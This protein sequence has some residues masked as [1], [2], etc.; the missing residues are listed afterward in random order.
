MENPSSTHPELIE[1]ISFLKQRIKELEQ[2]ESG[3]RQAEEELRDNESKY[4]TLI[5]TTDTGFVIIDKDGL[6]LDANP[7]YV[8]LTGHRDLSEIVGR[9]VIE[10]TAYSEKGKNAAAIKAALEKGYIRNLEIDYV[11]SKGSITPIEINAMSMEID[12]KIQTVT[13]CRDITERKRAEEA[14]RTSE[15]KFRKEQE[16]SQLLLDTSPALIVAIG[17]DGK[18]LM[19]NQAL[20]DVIEYTKEEI[21]GVDYLNT[22]V[23]EE[24]RGMLALV[25]QQIINEGKATVNKNRIR[26]R[27]GR[28]YLV[29]WHGRTVIQTEGDSDFFVGVGIDI[30]ER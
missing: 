29:E 25:F 10:W 13:I 4:R 9:S 15:V 19:I 14:L 20:L 17:F 8:R 26:S 23:P 24:D 2:S 3:H 12:G 21:T 28:T 11:D 1:E 6:V 22:F 30:T 16:F 18:T 27:S 5:E 7:E